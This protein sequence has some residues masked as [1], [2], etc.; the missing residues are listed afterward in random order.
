MQQAV[1][2]TLTHHPLMRV[3]VVYIKILTRAAL[4]VKVGSVYEKKKYLI[5]AKV[6]CYSRQYYFLVIVVIR[7]SWF[8]AFDV[9]D[10]FPAQLVITVWKI[11]QQCSIRLILLSLW[12]NDAT[13]ATKPSIS[14]I[15]IKYCS[16]RN[17]KNASRSKN[18]CWGLSPVQQAVLSGVFASS[19][20]RYSNSS[21]VIFAT[22]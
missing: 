12:G 8:K 4:T 2:T 5:C 16:S 7:K 9:T 20:H 22:F 11:W 17:C 14:T 13:F 18:N 21:E 6:N 1:N 19:H 15:Q 10:I 3:F